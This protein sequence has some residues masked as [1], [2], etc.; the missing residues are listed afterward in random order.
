MRKEDIRCNRHFTSLL[1]LRRT[2]QWKPSTFLAVEEIADRFSSGLIRFR[3]CRAL[4]GAHG[5]VDDGFFF[6]RFTAR[7]AA[8]GETGLIGL[9][10]KLTGTYDTDSNWK[11]HL[12]LWY[13]NRF[14]Y[15]RGK[16]IQK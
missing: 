13:W 16:S 7:R 14:Q 15:S 5:A 6:F 3:G 4:K 9:Q 2:G 1:R 11:R 12:L 8:V 10:F